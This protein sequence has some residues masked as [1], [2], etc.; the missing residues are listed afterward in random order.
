[1]LSIV[2]DFL[3]CLCQGRIVARLIAFRLEKLMGLG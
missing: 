3:N 2:L 1:M